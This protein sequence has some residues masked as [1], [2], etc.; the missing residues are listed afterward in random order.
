MATQQTWNIQSLTYE[1]IEQY[2]KKTK[3][4]HIDAQKYNKEKYADN[5][6]MASLLNPE[7]D[8]KKHTI[9]VSTGTVRKWFMAL[10][11]KKIY[12]PLKQGKKIVYDELSLKIGSFILS[13][14]HETNK[15][16]DDIYELVPNEF[17]LSST[18][19][20]KA[21]SKQK[22]TKTR[23]NEPPTNHKKSNPDLVDLIINL[24]IEAEKVW[25][26]SPSERKINFIKYYIHNHL[27]PHE[28]PKSQ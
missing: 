3:K 22:K 21:Q 12:S 2:K 20:K 27:P 9:T 11:K 4:R 8:D 14:R 7:W 10:E 16:L 13:M 28:K 23:K 6:F 24:Q 18:P 19:L 1:M 5:A 26:T 17:S 15:S 25:E